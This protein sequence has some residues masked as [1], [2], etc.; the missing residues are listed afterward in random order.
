MAECKPILST[1]RVLLREVREADLPTFFEHQRD[2]D[3]NRMAAFPPRDK[4]A[5]TAHWTKIMGDESLIIRTILF[6]GAVAGNIGSWEKDGRR[7]VGYW[8]GKEFWGRGIASRALFAFI[9]HDKARPLHA[10][11]AKNN[12]ASIRVLEKCG[13]TIAG[14]DIDSSEAGDEVVEEFVYVLR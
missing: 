7:L 14:E 13:F 3:A 11:V 1:N 10:Y 4:D 6:D 12:V 9:G 5:F 8:I 2:P